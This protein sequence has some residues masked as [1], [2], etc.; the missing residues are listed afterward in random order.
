MNR[1]SFVTSIGAAALA[2]PLLSQLR[3]ADKAAAFSTSP[4]FISRLQPAVVGGGFELPDHWVSCG[5]P[6]R[7]E[8]GKYHPVASRIPKTVIFHPHWLF[9]SEIVRDVADTRGGPYK[10]AEVALPPRGGDFFDARSTHNPHIR[11]I[12]DTFVL[13]YMGTNDYGPTPDHDHQEVWRS[14]R[15]LATWARKRIGLATSKRVKGPWKRFDTPPIAS[16][17]TNGVPSR[18]LI[19]PSARTPTAR[20]SSLTNPAAKPSAISKSALPTPRITPARGRASPRH[21]CFAASPRTWKIR[22]SGMKTVALTR[23]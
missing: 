3:P 16:G 20:S 9:C 4:S 17:P 8:D 19:P 13:L 12:G 1:R 2:T 22:S 5:A 23:S 18:R 21:G 6:I 15:H 11:K 10:F 7:G 14:P